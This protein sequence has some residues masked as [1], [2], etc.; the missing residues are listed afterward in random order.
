LTLSAKSLRSMKSDY[1][2][3]RYHRTNP[4]RIALA[5]SVFEEE[6][7]D[8]FYFET[9]REQSVSITELVTSTLDILSESVEEDWVRNPAF[10]R[11]RAEVRAIC[12]AQSILTSQIA[13]SFE[14]RFRIFERFRGIQDSVSIWLLTLLACIF[15]PMS[16]ASAILSMQTR[17]ANLHFL[18]YDFCGIMIIITSLVMLVFLAM[19][20]SIFLSDLLMKFIA[21][22]R[23]GEFFR[24]FLLLPVVAA[25]SIMILPFWALVFTSFMVGMIKDVGLGLKILGYG[26][27]AYV[28]IGFVLVA[29]AACVAMY[30]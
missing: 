14:S 2:E 18:L 26:C 22:N 3:K 16:L 17:L 7:N 13:E 24:K 20:L 23:R 28:G 8:A 12:S 9:L 19:K 21:N 15:L 4:R 5:R 10:R 30:S 1:T 29:L 6:M 25:G 11:M 27:A